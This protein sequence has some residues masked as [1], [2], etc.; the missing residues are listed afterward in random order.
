MKNHDIIEEAALSSFNHFLEEDVILKVARFSKKELSREMYK[1]EEYICDSTG[2]VSPLFAARMAKTAQR[3]Y[4]KGWFFLK[5][6]E[7]VVTRDEIISKWDGEDLHFDM[8]WSF[9]MMVNVCKRAVCEFIGREYSLT[10]N[11]TDDD[12]EVF[13]TNNYCGVAL[14]FVLGALDIFWV[15]D[16]YFFDSKC[17][18]YT[19]IEYF[20][21]KSDDCDKIEERNIV[22]DVMFFDG[23]MKF[24]NKVDIRRII[25]KFIGDGGAFNLRRMFDENV[26]TLDVYKKVIT[27]TDFCI[28]FGMNPSSYTLDVENELTKKGLKSVLNVNRDFRDYDFA[29]FSKESD[30]CLEYNSYD[31]EDDCLDY[32]NYDDDNQPFIQHNESSTY[33]LVTEFPKIEKKVIQPKTKEPFNLLGRKELNDFFNESIIDVVN[34]FDVYS[35]FGITFPEPFILEGPPGCGK[36]FAVNKLEEYLGWKTFH[37]TSS[38]V[39][40]QFIHETAKKIEN[41]FNEAKKHNCSMVVIDEME[42]FMPSRENIRFSDSHH[43]EEVNSFLKC[44][45]TAQENNILVVGMTNYIDKID[46][47]ILRSGRMGTHIKVSWASEEEIKQV[48]GSELDKRPYDKVNINLSDYAPRFHERPLS[49]VTAVVRRASMH[50]A[51]RRAERVCKEDIDFAMDFILRE[52]EEEKNNDRVIG[53][54]AC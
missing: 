15:G 25:S 48:M 40:S 38:T 30:D 54:S 9:N 2:L 5:K 37:I 41:T 23:F 20:L 35:K 53:F 32:D 46:P 8:N 33:K 12:I 44:I 1:M 52:S 16:E 28:R 6:D 29:N 11:S 51:R 17:E 27:T 13:D 19:R 21:S 43:V 26:I 31:V 22:D 14:G 7:G 4:S 10:G 39:G 42:S 49:D 18:L 34:N 36:T 3:I 24:K 50:A 45:Q 47:A